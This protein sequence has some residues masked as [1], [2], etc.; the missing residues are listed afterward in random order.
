MCDPLG[1]HG[2]P[3]REAQ[4]PVFTPTFRRKGPAIIRPTFR[5]L[6]GSR[7]SEDEFQGQLHKAAWQGFRN[8]AEVWRTDVVVRQPEV[9][10]VENVEEL[11]AEL[12]AL[13]LANRNVLECGEIPLF[14]AGSFD[15]VAA[16]IA[17][18]SGLRGRIEG[19][20]GSLVEPFLRSARAVIRI[21]D[22]IRPVAGEAGDLRGAALERD[23][24]GIVDSERRATH[25]RGDAVQLPI[26]QDLLIPV[27][28]MIPERNPPFVAEHK[29]V[30]RIEHGPAA[31]RR[32]IKRVLCQVVLSRDALRSGASDIEGRN[33]VDGLRQSVGSQE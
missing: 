21:A 15:D 10:V 24:L 12:Q 6:A 2:K 18:L 23:I 9:S 14:E 26:A 4:P 5:L 22:E 7:C 1:P 13:G 33:I 31:F 11:R 17:E 27:L 20:K 28:W 3:R 25:E 19:L 29:P 30:A 32:E 16:F 8:F